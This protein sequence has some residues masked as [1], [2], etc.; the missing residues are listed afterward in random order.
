ML[1]KSPLCPCVVGFPSRRTEDS[2][3]SL[4][5][6]VRVA[7][8]V[9]ISSP[10]VCFVEGKRLNGCSEEARK[11]GC[12]RGNRVGETRRRRARFSFIRLLDDRA[13]ALQRIDPPIGIG[14]SAAASEYHPTWDS[15]ATRPDSH[16][17]RG[18]FAPSRRFLSSVAFAEKRLLVRREPLR[19]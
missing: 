17:S 2:C 6:Q 4:V 10:T 14:L 5:R 19:R 7:V 16:A 12:C 3:S 13:H 15:L 9:K 11:A 8:Y 18:N 1:I